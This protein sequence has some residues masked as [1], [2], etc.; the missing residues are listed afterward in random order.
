MHWTRD[1][2]TTRRTQPPRFSRE[3]WN[4][5]SCRRQSQSSM[6]S[7][8][9]WW[10]IEHLGTTSQIFN[11]Q[12]QRRRNTKT[13]VVDGVCNHLHSASV[14]H[15]TFQSRKGLG[16]VDRC[17]FSKRIIRAIRQ[18]IKISSKNKSCNHDCD[19]ILAQLSMKPTRSKR[20]HNYPTHHRSLIS[21]KH[22]Q[23]HST[24]FK[25]SSVAAQKAELCNL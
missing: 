8:L 14:P 5:Y 25:H 23:I 18:W 6:H 10:D 21:N 9:V 20:A 13:K 4:T 3:A 24:A 1:L 11:S 12:N 2:L 15:T 17:N 19:G 22:F 7:S 16:S